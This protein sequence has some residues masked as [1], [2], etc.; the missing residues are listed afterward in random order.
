MRATNHVNLISKK[1]TAGHA[2]CRY[3][4]LLEQLNKRFSLMGITK[5]T[6]KI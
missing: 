2:H 3:F 4:K 6:T 5:N 1:N